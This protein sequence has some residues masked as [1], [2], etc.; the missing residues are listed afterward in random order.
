MIPF[1]LLLTA[2]LLSASIFNAQTGDDPEKFGAELSI[3]IGAGTGPVMDVAVEGDYAFAIGKGNLYVL[4]ITSSK[5]PRIVGKI[6]GLGSVRQIEVRKGIAYVTSRQD[7]LFIVD[8]K[9]PTKP[10]LLNHYDTVEFATGVA[11]SG[12]VLFVACRNYG[13]ELVDVSDPENPSHICL[14]RTGE[15][16]SL[17]ARDGYLYVGVWATS[18]VV[19]VDVKNPWK[20]K[21]TA[22]VPLDG[23]GDGVDVK[24]DFLYAATGHHSRETPRKNPGDPGF[25]RGHGLEVF[26]LKDPAQPKFVSRVKFPPLYQIGNDMWDVTIAN[27]HAFVADTW[28]G[29]FVVDVG[30]PQNMKI[31]RHWKT[32]AAEDGKKPGF[33]GGL[34]VVKGQILVAGGYSDLHLVAA[35]MADFPKEESDNAPVIA[36]ANSEPEAGMTDWRIYR[37]GGQVY[38][39][40]L[41][42][43]DRAVV[44]CGSAGVHVVKIGK[45][46]ELLSVLPTEGFA[47]DVSI[48]GNRIFVAESAGGL[49][50]WESNTGDDQ[51]F[52]RV[53][54]FELKGKA[55]RQVETPD[56]GDRIMIQVG[57]NHFYILDVS[58]PTK[59]KQ[60][61]EDTRH[62]LLYGDQMMRGLVEN[63]YTAVQWHVSGIFW[64]DITA[65][66]TPIYSGD[67]F[68]QRIGSKNS[69]I[70]F[71][72]KTLATVRGGYVL[73]DRSERRPISE[74]DVHRIGKLR[75]NPGVPNISE[76]FLYT[77]DRSTG[78]VTISDISDPGKPRLIEQFVT[79]G[80]PC[81]IEAQNG[82][83]AIP[84]GYHGL[85]IKGR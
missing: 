83:I 85:M 58:D 13:V 77:A 69:M 56:A 35:E 57:S 53:G 20:P 7:G 5:K 10:K 68:G 36:E 79:P 21:I 62:G 71:G 28:N 12:K 25:G 39:V 59:P 32:P 14:V 43:D 30:D 55:I 50:I 24:G 67:N 47:M 74:L 3:A 41:Y 42:G 54:H 9:N 22:K 64:Y 27:G 63:R 80:N 17:V 46:I 2:F 34:S 75:G 44:A 16:Q 26:D 52:E 8:V 31:V 73:L 60:I 65:K 19:V 82:I 81:R 66:P 70:A 29:I 15:A 6:L 4:D 40:A 84:D 76:N 49:S 78:L 51:G 72:K 23:Y 1:R 48:S 37:P 11:L 61:F 33:V 38:G 18:E 45:K